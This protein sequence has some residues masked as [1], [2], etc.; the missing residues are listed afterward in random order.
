VWGG[1]DR[2][3]NIKVLNTDIIRKPRKIEQELKWWRG[4]FLDKPQSG[5]LTY[6]EVGGSTIL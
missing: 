6:P 4:R 5:L 3:K 1:R 2:I